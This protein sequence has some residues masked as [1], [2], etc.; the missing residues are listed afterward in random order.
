VKIQQVSKIEVIKDGPATDGIGKPAPITKLALSNED[1][2]AG[3][4]LNRAHTSDASLYPKGA[5][6]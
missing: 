3:M 4:R 1:C 6:A 5:E 2:L